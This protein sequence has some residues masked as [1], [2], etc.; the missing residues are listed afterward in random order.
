MKAVIERLGVA[1]SPLTARLQQPTARAQ[2][3]RRRTL[4]AALV[5]Q[6]KQAVGAYGYRRGLGLLRRQHE[7]GPARRLAEA[8]T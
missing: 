1:R 6:N 4:D 2:P 8:S 7:P 5:E 3:R